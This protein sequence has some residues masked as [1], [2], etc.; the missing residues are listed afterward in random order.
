M[1]SLRKDGGR[2]GD[3]IYIFRF[4]ENYNPRR[5][6]KADSPRN[7]KKGVMEQPLQLVRSTMGENGNNICLKVETDTELWVKVSTANL[8]LV[9]EESGRGGAAII[10][11]NEQFELNGFIWDELNNYKK[12][13]ETLTGRSFE[14]VSESSWKIDVPLRKNGGIDFRLDGVYQFLIS[15]DGHEDLGMAAINEDNARADGKLRLVEGTGFG[16]SHGTCKHSAPT[17]KISCDTTCTFLLEK[18]DDTKFQ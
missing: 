9:I 17:I 15:R 3:G 13:D 7:S 12:F 18:E 14:R 5:V 6:L 11:S 4:I 16:S 1:F 2:H 10:Q 8:S